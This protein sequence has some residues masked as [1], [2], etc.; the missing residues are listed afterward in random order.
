MILSD[1]KKFIFFHLYK[2][3]GTSLSQILKPYSTLAR[4]GKHFKVH[5][6][7]D[8]YGKSKYDDYYTFGF[9]RNPW[10]WQVSL[11]HYM[12]MDRGHFQHNLVKSF[13]TYEEYLIWR[14]NED[15]KPQYTFFSENGD[16]SS[17]ITLNHIGKFEDLHDEINS[18]QSTLNIAGSLPHLVKSK[19]T[20]YKDYYNEKTWNMLR[21]AYEKDVEYFGYGEITFQ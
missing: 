13:K 14:V 17:P 4:D 5:Q 6:Y 15:C 12:L 2:T 11:Y 10:D 16:Q 8:K 3:A 1:N 19:H 7:L 18:L 21:E 9:V 20:H